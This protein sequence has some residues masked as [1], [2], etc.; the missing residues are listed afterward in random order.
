[1]KESTHV[2][3]SKQKLNQLRQFRKFFVITINIAGKSASFY[4]PLLFNAD[5]DFSNHH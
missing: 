2:E 3:A 5:I 1:M 4:S